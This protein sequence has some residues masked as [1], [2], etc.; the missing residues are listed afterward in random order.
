[1]NL[2]T[3]SMRAP[4]WIASSIAFFSV[5]SCSDGGELEQSDV[6]EQVAECGPEQIVEKFGVLPDTA[7]L[8]MTAGDGAQL[9]P[10]YVNQWVRA[11]SMA[12]DQ[13][14]LVFM[15]V[16]MADYWNPAGKA[17]RV[18]SSTD[19]TV[20]VSPTNPAHL[21]TG[22]GASPVHDCWFAGTSCVSSLVISSTVRLCTAYNINVN[23][24]SINLFADTYGIPRETVALAAISHEM[25]HASGLRHRNGNTMMRSALPV[26]GFDGTTDW[27]R[28][29]ACEVKA[30]QAYVPD[31]DTL[32]MVRVDPPP[33]CL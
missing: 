12:A 23:F 13:K 27:L 30:L 5:L 22:C 33:E 7:A 21:W 26:P 32:T 17:Y 8:G 14:D 31:T 3:H 24:P 2:M 6:E 25:G 28:F 1:M 9:Y 4:F 16:A 11:Y 10:A 20:S 15:G 18:D 29:D 19:A